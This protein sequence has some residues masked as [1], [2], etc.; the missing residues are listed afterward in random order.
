MA[1]G[2]QVLDYGCGCGYGTFIL[3]KNAKSVYGMDLDSKAIEFAKRYNNAKNIHYINDSS[4]SDS[5]DLIV[6]VEV[7]EHIP[8]RK[9]K[10]FVSDLRKSLAD[11]GLMVFTTPIMDKTI[12]HHLVSSLHDH[13]R[14]YNKEGFLKVLNK[15][16]LEIKQ[17]LLQKYDGS[18]VY[19]VPKDTRFGKQLNLGSWVQI[20]VCGKENGYG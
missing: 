10:A 16:S 11:N 19:Q 13:Y 3:S 17:Y 7:L 18:L 8:P 6:A 1:Y 15:N 2:K 4:Y 20:A 14:E 5:F 9:V 12:T